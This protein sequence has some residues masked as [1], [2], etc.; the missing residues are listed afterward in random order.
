MNNPFSPF[1]EFFSKYWPQLPEWF[2]KPILILILLLFA[3][4]VTYY[5][6]KLIIFIIQQLIKILVYTR[7]EGA[8]L[9]YK[10]LLKK[11]SK[12]IETLVNWKISRDKN[13]GF[14]YKKVK[15]QHVNQGDEKQFAIAFTKSVVL[16]LKQNIKEDKSENLVKA[17]SNSIIFGFLANVRYKMSPE[18]STAINNFEIASK[19][20]EIKDYNAEKMFL[21][22]QI[23]NP[24]IQ[25]YVS[26]IELIDR[27]GLYKSFLIPCLKRLDKFPRSKDVIIKKE[28]EAFVEWLGAEWIP[29]LVHSF[30]NSNHF[31]RTSFVYF[32]LPLTPPVAHLN[33]AVHNFQVEM[34]DIVILSAHKGFEKYLKNTSYDLKNKY[35]FPNIDSFWG[36]REFKEGYK[37]LF[38]A[39]HKKREF[40]F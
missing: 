17:V 31:P 4:T 25:K 24:K 21:S 30:K 36:L 23:I 6:I 27:E 1:F 2:K 33:R 40:E 20:R 11:E 5:I 38:Y 7:Y 37:P 13:H 8:Y 12:R 26:L 28:L 14:S 39:I 35:D 18:V 29:R 16:V 19:L 22:Q 10:F 32:K 3:G 34:C 15:I 9:F